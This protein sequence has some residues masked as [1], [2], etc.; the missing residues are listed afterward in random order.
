MTSPDLEKTLEQL[1]SAL[2]KTGREGGK[3]LVVAARAFRDGIR[4]AHEKERAERQAKRREL[5]AERRRQRRL[6]AM[7]RASVPGGL[8]ELLVAAALVVFGLLNPQFWWLLFVALGIGTDGAR[9]LSLAGQRRRLEGP[10]QD[11]EVTHERHEV[12]VLCDQLLVDL[13]AS[14]EA[15]RS[16]LQQ[17]EK[18]IEALRSTAK[19]VDQRRRALGSGET[20][21]QLQSLATQ[22]THL[23]EKRDGAVDAAAREKFDAALRSLDGQ[24]AALQ[25]FQAASERLDGEYTSLVVL[26]QELKTRVAVARSTDQH[27]VQLDGLQQNVQRLNAELQAITESL[28]FTAIDEQVAGVS[29]PTSDRQR[30][31][32]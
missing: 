16:F 17:P 20:R 8:F 2:E 29:A 5:K 31:R 13:K 18:T 19:A 30:E 1:S 32:G 7:E 25:Q 11:D 14:P 23:R 10:A 9:Q 27:H 26:L 15:V 4:E 28:Q 3:A 22:R 12:D 24:E 21:H 6:E